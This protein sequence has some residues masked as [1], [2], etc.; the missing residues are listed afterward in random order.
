MPQCACKRT[1]AVGH[2]NNCQTYLFG[3][4]QRCTPTSKAAAPHP[5]SGTILSS[6]QP[7]SLCRLKSDTAA[8]SPS[9]SDSN[10]YEK[11]ETVEVSPANTL[12]DDTVPIDPAAAAVRR[13]VIAFLCTLVLFWI[14]FWSAFFI[15]PAVL[16]SRGLWE[17]RSHLL[18]WASVCQAY[19]H[20]SANAHAGVPHVI[21]TH[22]SPLTEA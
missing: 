11:A 17:P 21:A 4:C 2:G 10:P 5:T 16:S 14:L 8:I 22:S 15:S 13:K 3:S 12:K 18:A 6:C 9:P 19:K 1:L 7:W 20:A